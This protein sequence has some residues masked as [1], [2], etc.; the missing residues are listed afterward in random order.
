MVLLFFDNY[1]SNSFLSSF[2]G[3][4]DLVR[5]VLKAHLEFILE[6]LIFSPVFQ[7]SIILSLK[8]FKISCFLIS[9]SV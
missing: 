8:V 7:V 1:L 3:E 9:N 2:I 6:Y 5:L 4:G